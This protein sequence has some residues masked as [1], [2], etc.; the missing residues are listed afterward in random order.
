MKTLSYF[1]RFVALNFS[2]LRRLL[3]DGPASIFGNTITSLSKQMAENNAATKKK[4]PSRIMM[5]QNQ[6]KQRTKKEIGYTIIVRNYRVR[7]GK[8]STSS[9]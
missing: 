4:K 1:E 9:M 5:L 8:I 2:E 3:T 6:K 7:T